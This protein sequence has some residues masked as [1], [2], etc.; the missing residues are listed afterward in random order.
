[1]S[2][3]E[4]RFHMLL[5]ARSAFD[6]G[7]LRID[8]TELSPGDAIPSDGDPRIDRALRGFFF[9][10]GPDHIRHPEPIAAAV[11][12]HFP[13]HGSV[14]GT[15]V[16][17]VEETVGGTVRSADIE[18]A[19]A[20]GGK[21]LL[22]RRWTL[23]E[24]GA[25]LADRITNIGMAPFAPMLMYHMNIAGR[26]FSDSTGITSTAFGSARRGW[27]FGE[28]E[29]AH[30]CLPAAA[31]EDGWA[32]VEVGPFEALDGRSLVVRFATETLPFLQMWRCQRGAA[33]VV[34]VEP[35]SHRIASR[36][37]LAAAGELPMLDP[38]TSLDYALAFD[39]L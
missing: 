35:V 25:S 34:S 19:L 1:M 30:F 4:K 22:S 16:L 33:D 2:G 38:G 36:V 15:P 27:R 37:D 18:I 7:T 21:A 5:N 26:L 10:C 28:G 39:V 31:G 12:S 20:T 23:R 13:L 32:R 3:S 24:S 9:T 8:G 17:R 29:S 11:G 6:I 14:C